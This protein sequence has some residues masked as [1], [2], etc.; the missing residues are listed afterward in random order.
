MEKDEI[1]KY[2]NKEIKVSSN[3]QELVLNEDDAYEED[4]SLTNL[5]IISTMK[6]VLKK[7]N[8]KLSDLEEDILIDRIENNLDY[9]TI[10]NKNNCSSKKI[11]NVIY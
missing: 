11:Y 6:E 2:L 5:D 4:F 10:A 8:R 7:T 3:T 9:R 1:L